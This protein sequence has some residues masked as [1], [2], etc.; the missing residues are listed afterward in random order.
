MRGNRR[1]RFWSSFDLTDLEFVTALKVLEFGCGEGGRC[2]ELVNAGAKTV[3]GLDISEVSIENALNDPL[4]ELWL[5]SKVLKFVAC[6]IRNLDDDGF[7]VVVSE[8][9]FEHLADLD[10]CL[11]E[12]VAR[13]KRGGTLYLGFAPLYYS[14]FGDHGWLRQYL[15]LFPTLSWPWGHLI[16]PKE[17]LFRRMSADHG[18]TI[19]GIAGWP[20]QHLNQL[21]LK[22]F[23]D[24]FSRAG[25]IVKSL[26]VNPAHSWK[27]KA[28]S[29]LAK[30]PAIGVFC[31][32]GVYIVLEKP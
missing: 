23:L 30:L 14:P 29:A 12:I 28:L 26:N 6:D 2:L 11:H 10:D 1:D 22:D 25:L 18:T 17:Y 13:M 20:Y 24:A 3:V 16:F 21:E 4:N 27:A 15:P 31:T 8:N 32:W 5:S 9:T 7:D 19:R